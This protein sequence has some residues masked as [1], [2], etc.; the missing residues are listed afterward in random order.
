[1]ALSVQL[2]LLLEEYLFSFLICQKI[3]LQYD[4][5]STY[6]NLKLR[7]EKI[8]ANRFISELTCLGYQVVSSN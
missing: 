3:L 4:D 1:M 7:Y 6:E 8:K 2:L 5:I